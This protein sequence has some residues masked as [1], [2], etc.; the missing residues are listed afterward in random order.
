MEAANTNHFS[1]LTWQKEKQYWAI[2][3]DLFY[4]GINLNVVPLDVYNH[5][6]GYA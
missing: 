1:S 2:D 4:A 6:L 5:P 3:N